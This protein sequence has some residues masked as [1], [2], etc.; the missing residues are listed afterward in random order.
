MIAEWQLVLVM[1]LVFWGGLMIVD[2][3]FNLE[4]YGVSVLPFLLICRTTKLNNILSKAALKAPH[5]WRIL[6]DA[7]IPLGYSA[8]GYGVYLLSLNLLNAFFR[9][10]QSSPIVPLIPG[11]TVT[12]FSFFYA[13]VGIVVTLAFHEIAHGLAARAENIP[14]KSSGVLFLLFLPGGFVEIDE[15]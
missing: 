11:I 12:W 1:L 14:I 15:E 10:Q 13:L 4:K 7:S 8:L 2:R 3:L 9:P 5:A 6:G